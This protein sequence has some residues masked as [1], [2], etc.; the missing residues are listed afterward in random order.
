MEELQLMLLR[1]L[2]EK[3]IVIETLPT[4]NVRIGHHHTYDTYHLWNWI[5][6]ENEGNPIPPIVVGTDDP[7]IFATNIYN[8]YS[9]I[10]CKLVY[11]H[12]VSRNQAMSVIEKLDKNSQIYK[13]N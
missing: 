9:N 13:F 2:N 5:K 8:E 3:E 4:S 12:H 10:Y 7:G 6:W 11:V 1:Y